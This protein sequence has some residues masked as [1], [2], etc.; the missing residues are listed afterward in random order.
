MRCDIGEVTSFFPKRRDRLWSLA[1]AK[2]LSR[3]QNKAKFRNIATGLEKELRLDRMP[4]HVTMCL[5]MIL[6]YA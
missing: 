5:L 2:R 4:Y 6:S 1:A 3:N